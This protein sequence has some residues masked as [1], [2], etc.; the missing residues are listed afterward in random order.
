AE[1]KVQRE[2][3]FYLP[4]IFHEPGDIVVVEIV[5]ADARDRIGNL[6]ERGEVPARQT[7]A[8]V[9]PLN[10]RGPV[11]EI[12]GAGVRIHA[13]TLEQVDQELVN[14]IHVDTCLDRV[15]ASGPRKHI[16]EL[17]AM[18]VGE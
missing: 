15:P 10:V 7:V 13:A 18:L 16:V 12:P 11:A 9:D 14:R 8:K 1:P 2:I 6:D 4:A 3:G 17:Q 5:L